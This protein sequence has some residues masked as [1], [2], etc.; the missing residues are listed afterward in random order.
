MMSTVRAEAS[1]LVRAP[2]RAVYQLLADYRDG[3]PRI[4][5]KRY[6]PWL[7]V[8]R[9]GVGAGTVI[10]FK[11]HA[12]GASREIRSEITEPTPGQVLAE[13]D[14]ATGA[15]TTFTVT[16]EGGGETCRVAIR[17]EWEGKGFRGWIERMT[18]PRLLQ[19][20]YAEELANL[21]ALAEGERMGRG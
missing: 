16:P 13:T 10:L 5:P 4:L 14:F 12:F 6:F 21:A 20:I 17:T 1:A 19:R 3:H 9:G 2:A 8:E 18:A 15:R 7:K 11:M